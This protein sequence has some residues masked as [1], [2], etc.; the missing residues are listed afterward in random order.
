MNDSILTLPGDIPGL[1]RR[2]SP[3]WRARAVGGLRCVCL[4]GAEGTAAVVLAAR[5]DKCTE[6]Y[7][8]TELVLDLSDPTARLH[9]LLWLATQ[10][11]ATIDAVADDMTGPIVDAIYW[12]WAGWEDDTGAPLGWELNL[13]SARYFFL[14][15]DVLVDLNHRDVDTLADGSRAVDA[16]ALRRI[17]LH[18]AGR[19]VI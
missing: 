9:A 19:P 16:E 6:W 17:V 8:S 14:N 11:V 4:T 1:L 7:K 12:A 3:V 5:S 15:D 18:V 13:W 10:K 2:G